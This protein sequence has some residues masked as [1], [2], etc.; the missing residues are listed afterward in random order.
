MFLD[1]SLSYQFSETD[2]LAPKLFPVTHL[3]FLV[4]PPGPLVLDNSPFPYLR[5]AYYCSQLSPGEQGRKQFSWRPR[6]PGV[7]AKAGGTLMS[8]AGHKCRVSSRLG[9]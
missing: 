9:L 2:R 7:L 3:R 1:P 6:S 5:V 8:G 4:G